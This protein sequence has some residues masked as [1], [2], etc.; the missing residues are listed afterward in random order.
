MNQISTKI[1]TFKEIFLEF[2]NSISLDKFSLIYPGFFE[3]NEINNWDITSL[4]EQLEQVEFYID[5]KFCTKNHLI[6]LF[7]H[8]Q[9]AKS[10]SIISISRTVIDYQKKNKCK[11]RQID[12]ISSNNTYTYNYNSKEGAITV[13]IPQNIIKHINND[14]NIDFDF[15]TKLYWTTSDIEKIFCKKKLN[16]IIQT[17]IDKL[18]QEVNNIT[19]PRLTE[20][21]SLN[22]KNFVLA[23]YVHYMFVRD[24]QK[25]SYFFS[26]VVDNK[27]LGGVFVIFKGE[28]DDVYA[29]LITNR[30]AVRLVS[31]SLLKLLQKKSLKT[32]LISILVDSYAHNISA[33]SLSALK[34]WFE[35][36]F[37]IL[38]RRFYVSDSNGDK[39]LEI[40]ALQQSPIVISQQE[41]EKSSALYYSALGL[42]DSK[43]NE[44]FYSLYDYLK[45]H[46]EDYSRLLTYTESNQF[47][48]GDNL[49]KVSGNKIN[50]ISLP[51]CFQPQFPVSLDYALFPFFRFLRD[52]GAFWSGVIRDMAFGGEIKNWYEILWKDFANNPLYLGTI[53]KTEGITKINI[54]LCIKEK[55]KIKKSG[56][57]VVIDLSIIDFEENVANNLGNG[58]DNKRNNKTEVGDIA[59][60]KYAFVRLGKEFKALREE[61]AS[62]EY[63]VYLPGG[64]VGEHALFTIFENT[65]RNIKHIKNDLT[66]IQE[67]GIDLYISIEKPSLYKDEKYKKDLY[68][69]GIWL[70]HPTNLK[71]T[72]NSSTITLFQKLTDSANKPIL[73][74]SG[75]AKM[76]GNSQDKACAAMLFTNN[77]ISV[78]EKDGEYK[79]FYPWLHYTTTVNKNNKPCKDE[80]PA[81]K[82][83]YIDEEC[84]KKKVKLY[85]KC[86]KDNSKGYCK[87]YFFIWQGGD[88]VVIKNNEELIANNNISRFKF[89]IVSGENVDELENQLKKRGITRIIKDL[90]SSL[91]TTLSKEIDPEKR[92]KILYLAW[93]KV[94]FENFSNLRIGFKRTMSTVG[95]SINLFTGQIC[96]ANSCANLF[97][98][99]ND[100]KNYDQT[101]HLSHGHSDENSECNVRSHGHFWNKYF[102]EIERKQPEVLISKFTECVNCVN[103]YTPLVT[104]ESLLY[105]F[106]EVA[107]TQVIIFDNRLWD[108]MPKSDE[109][110]STFKE[111]LKLSVYKEETPLFENFITNNRDTQGESPLVLII[112]LS[113][114]EALGYREDSM[115][116]FIEQKL[117]TF[118]K[119]SNFRLIIVSGR[120]RDSWRN[121]MSDE[122]LQ[123]T[124]YKPVESFINA[125]ESGVSYNDNF[126][127]KYNIIKVIFGS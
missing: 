89:V 108:R 90:D 118:I 38:D 76:G 92:L 3:L 85:N 53:A 62:E 52:K 81:M 42:S 125:I 54:H 105:D 122:Y 87:K 64:L 107:A 59:Y 14:T 63:N 49:N 12:I 84:Y 48:D 111:Q 100:Q 50:D 32:A 61:L 11:I 41:L 72:E 58:Q 2:Y 39:S 97:V 13:N 17:I 82:F 88:Y 60:S 86:L 57:F 127:V 94:W 106:M 69:V 40:S 34:W 112:H 43:Y 21:D 31:N 46:V 30:L 24:G 10:L 51:L 36:R 67:N 124:S 4:D 121:Q 18:K 33:H 68:K 116:C 55:G 99:D 47:Q 37:K 120:G 123:N 1:N 29:N 25:L 70:Q 8:F 77:F 19:F 119:R 23:C 26:D 126:D 45:F 20:S 78:D 35:L 56:Q 91:N 83:D 103:N 79:N 28:A 96:L 7:L 110:T 93:F 65:L 98:R 114:I 44:E 73:D 6:D 95:Y 27:G 80:L 71:V 115:N 109:K 5:D 9:I 104:N 66:N 15:K 22:E 16:G 75:I 117:P 113:F 101:I 102:P 74:D